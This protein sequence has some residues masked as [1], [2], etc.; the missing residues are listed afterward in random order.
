MFVVHPTHFPV[1]QGAR[2][3]STNIRN[4][5]RSPSLEERI[6]NLCEMLLEAEAEGAEFDRVA[7]EL[8]S[9]LTDHIERLGSRLR[10]YPLP[11][12][13]CSRN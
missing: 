9:A 7:E 12:D 8:R 2:T 10:Q 6:R 5:A 11:Q 1:W 13:W 3:N 4:R